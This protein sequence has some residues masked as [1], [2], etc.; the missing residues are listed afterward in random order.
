MRIGIILALLFICIHA[1]ENKYRIENNLFVDGIKRFYTINLPKEYGELKSLPVIIAMHGG[2]GSG[3]QCEKDYDLNSTALPEKFAVVYPDGVRG[4]GLLRVRTWN[5]G[6]CCEDA[7][8]NNINDVKFISNLIEELTTK[9]KVDPKRVY[10][11]GMSN[12]A[13]M[14]Y[15]LACEISDKIAAIAVVSGTM[16]TKNICKPNQVVPIL[17]IH[18]ERDKK[19]PPSGGKGIRGYYFPSVDSTL[20]EWATFDKCSA[21]PLV[22]KQKNYTKF[23][24]KNESS[25]EIIEYYL[26]KDGGHSWPGSKKSRLLADK[27]SKAIDANSLIVGFFKKH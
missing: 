9:Y 10:L 20:K 14:A 13:M 6:T 15:R 16:T 22:D 2:G 17:H 1:E 23:V 24:W 7:V 8:E 4:D 12:G 21:E 18:S 11:T 25:Q 5:A 3:E 27:P 19:V 26:T